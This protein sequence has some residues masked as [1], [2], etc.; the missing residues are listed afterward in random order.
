MPDT[1]TWIPVATLDDLWEGEV[2]EVAVEDRPIL[3]AHLPGGEVRA[4]DGLCP[5]A[6]FPLVDGEVTDGVLT[7]P[8]HSW[9]FD[10]ESGAGVNPS[11]CT[12]NRHQVRLD[13]DR[14]AISLSQGESA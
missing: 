11:T 12:L 6:G 3:L 10:L 14:I 9:E 13:G 2:I 5:H 4:Y 7:C 1:D 8:A